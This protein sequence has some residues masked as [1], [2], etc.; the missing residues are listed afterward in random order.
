VTTGDW[1][2]VAGVIVVLLG[3]PLPF[4]YE[5]RPITPVPGSE[6]L[7]R[8]K[9]RRQRFWRYLIIWNVALVAVVTANMLLR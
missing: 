9:E 5:L 1:W 3:S 8:W 6:R 2:A 4:M 7:A